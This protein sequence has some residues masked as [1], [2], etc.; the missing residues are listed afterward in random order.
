[1]DDLKI[2]QTIQKYSQ[3]DQHVVLATVVEALG[4]TP[5]K[6]SA[7]MLLLP[8]G[9]FL[10]TVG[11]GCVEGRVKIIAQKILSCEESSPATIK[12]DLL[13]EPGYGEMD[14]C[15]GVMKVM[16]EKF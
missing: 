3:N 13:G 8:D 4:A 14:V 16:L 12:V 5:R 15:G 11:G 6:E 9:S 10:G 1:M 2:Y 7:K